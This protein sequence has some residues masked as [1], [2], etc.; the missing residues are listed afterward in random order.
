MKT[1]YLAGLLVLSSVALLLFS[2]CSMPNLR[3]GGVSLSQS[4][5]TATHKQNN[6]E[7]D[8]A[9]V[10]LA[11]PVVVGREVDFAHHSG[12]VGQ[13]HRQIRRTLQAR[14]V[15][16]VTHPDQPHDAEVRVEITV[17]PNRDDGADKRVTVALDVLDGGYFLSSGQSSSL[18]V[19]NLTTNVGAYQS[20]DRIVAGAMRHL[21]AYRIG[22]HLSGEGPTVATNGRQ[23]Q[24]ASGA[25]DVAFASATPQRRAYAL[26]IGVEAYRDL[27]PPTGARSDAETFAALLRETMGLPQENVRLLVDDRATR[28][29]I[30]GQLE[31]LEENVSAGDRVYVYFSGHGSPEPAEGTSYLLPYEATPENMTRTG[32]QL[33]EVIDRLEDTP[34]REVLAFVDACFSGMGDRS[35]IPEGTRPLVPA[36]G[37]VPSSRVAVFSASQANQIS[38]NRPGQDIGLFTHY[39]VEA[40]GQGR[41]DLD[42]DGQISLAELEAYVSPRVSREALEAERQQTPSLHIAQDLGDSDD[43]VVVWGISPE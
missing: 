37:A 23:P 18:M 7:W 25:R 4:N 31:W 15:Q 13:T 22:R 28:S 34:A 40:L 35:V 1:P 38:G 2:G 32:V 24:T 3:V 14:N 39:L 6:D 27:P 12:L 10:Y 21:F 5:H 9:T 19:N 11:D 29:D 41:A 42:G 30:I 20:L 17:E 16:V 36:Q 33:Q 8:G 26:V 43:V